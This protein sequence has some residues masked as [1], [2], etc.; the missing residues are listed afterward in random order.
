M[1]VSG[2][3]LPVFP[4]TRPPELSGG[5][6]GHYPVVVVG[7]GLTGLTLAAELGRRGIPVVLLEQGASASA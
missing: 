1:S 4:F 2:Y 6:P 7:A 3:R 5:P